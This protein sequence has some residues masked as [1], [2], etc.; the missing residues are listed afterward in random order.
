MAVMAVNSPPS[1]TF[2]VIS[3][4]NLVLPKNLR[5]TVVELSSRA[6][7]RVTDI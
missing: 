3:V 6:K 1:A 7:L 2:F 5:A 4:R